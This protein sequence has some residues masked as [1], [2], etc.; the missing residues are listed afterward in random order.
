MNFREAT[1][2]LNS[3][4]LFGIKFGLDNIRIIL[5]ALNNPHD[6]FDS[7]LVA[8]TNGKGSVC[9]F[10]TRVVSLH[11]YKV[12]LYT[13]P[14]LVSVRE[15]IRVNDRLISEKD[16]ANL[17][18]LLKK[19]IDE[20]VAAGELLTPPTYFEF[21][22][23]LAFTYFAQQKIDLGI[24][25]VGLGG[26]FDATNILQ[27]LCSVITSIA[28][29]HEKYLGSSLVQ[30]AG[31]KGGIIKSGRPVI[32]AVTAPEAIQTLQRKA[33][34]AAA[35]FIKVLEQKDNL[36][37]LDRKGFKIRFKLIWQGEEYTFTPSLLGG[38]QGL[39]AACALVTANVLARIWRPLKREKIV[40]GLETTTWEG[41]LEIL[42]EAPLFII[43]GAHNVSGARALRE[44][45]DEFLPPPDV[46]IFACMRDKRISEIAEI[47]FP[48]ARKII[49]TRFPYHR[50]AFPQEIYQKV[51]SYQEKTI[52][53]PEVFQALQA[54]RKI[55]PPQGT[56]IAA[57]S[58]YLVGEI[59]KYWPLLEQRRID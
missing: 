4:Q 16:F 56:I 29:D 47:L 19:K 5:N 53:V 43:D 18:F 20:L 30:V 1:L 3:L 51:T 21:L 55:V 50:S 39:N 24:I 35:P 13:S 9:A 15:R 6:S 27:P 54:A 49:L 11:G 22:T 8:G 14:H 37:A 17:T 38:H 32:T 10:L 46:L 23:A 25:E 12:G 26:R 59:K 33:A 58:L 52:M 36:R 44:F 45:M 2:Y 42:S 31:E 57:G 48:P 40:A 34:A 28:L 7:I 41:R